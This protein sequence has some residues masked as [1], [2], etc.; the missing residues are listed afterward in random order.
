MTTAAVSALHG[1]TGLG[2]S[3]RAHAH[4]GT[5]FVEILQNCPVF[6]DGAWGEL[7]KRKSRTEASLVLENGQPL[8]FGGI[9]HRRGIGLDGGIPTLIDL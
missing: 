1:L 2:S 4:R 6:F 8:V 3:R 5:S 9:E 7:E